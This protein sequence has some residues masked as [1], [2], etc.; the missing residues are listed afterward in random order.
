[1]LFKVCDVS[2]LWWAAAF[3]CFQSERFLYNSCP[4]TV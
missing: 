4:F 2:L 1:M 3:Q